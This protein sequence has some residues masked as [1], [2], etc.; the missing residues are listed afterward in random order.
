MRSCVIGVENRQILTTEAEIV[1]YAKRISVTVVPIWAT[2]SMGTGDILTA[3]A[4]IAGI[5]RSGCGGRKNRRRTRMSEKYFFIDCQVME[6]I[7][8]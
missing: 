3:Y 5:H 4:A 6:M 2:S 7:I 1:L 8:A